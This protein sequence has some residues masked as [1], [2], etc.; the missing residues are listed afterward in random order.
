MRIKSIDNVETK[1]MYN[2]QREKKLAARWHIHIYVFI[3]NGYVLLQSTHL[4]E[5]FSFVI[6]IRM[7]VIGWNRF[8]E[9]FFYL[10]FSHYFYSRIDWGSDNDISFIFSTRMFGENFVRTK[11]VI[12]QQITAMTTT[13]TATS[14]DHNDNENDD[15]QKVT[16]QHRNQNKP[17][18]F[19]HTHTHTHTRHTNGGVLLNFPE[20]KRGKLR[21]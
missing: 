9:N 6:V 7:I 12:D 1:Y 11:L 19:K 2:K 17:N 18:F 20:K 15:N 14:T 10:L 16:E 21:K 13:M 8:L 4:H 3:W 5:Q